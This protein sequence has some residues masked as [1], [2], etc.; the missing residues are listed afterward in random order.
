M[1][2]HQSLSAT[3]AGNILATFAS[4]NSTSLQSQLTALAAP[5]RVP[6]ADS[7]EEERQEL[8]HA[9]AIEVLS[10]DGTASRRKLERAELLRGILRQF[11]DCSSYER[12]GGVVPFYLQ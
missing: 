7:L 10:T 6:P 3:Q 2:V 12:Q 11:A 5:S 4:T 8:V 9:I 1:S